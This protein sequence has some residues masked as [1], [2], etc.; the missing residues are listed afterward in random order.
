MPKLLSFSLF[1]HFLMLSLTHAD[2][3]YAVQKVG[4]IPGGSQVG[5]YGYETTGNRLTKIV[6]GES[7]RNQTIEYGLIGKVASI[8]QVGFTSSIN[9]GPG[10]RR[11]LKV[12]SDG[13]KTFHLPGMDYKITAD[14]TVTTSIRINAKGYSPVAQVDIDSSGGTEYSYFVQDHL[15]SPVVSC[16][17]TGT[18]QT[19]IRYDVWG[20][21]TEATGV[22]NIPNTTAEIE[23]AEKNRGYTGHELMAKFNIGQWNGRIFDYEIGAFPQ[24]DKFI[25]GRSIAAL[26]RYALGQNNNPNVTD[27]SGWLR[28]TFAPS[29]AEGDI[30]IMAKTAFGGDLAHQRQKWL[31][32]ASSVGNDDH[33]LELSRESMR[34]GPFQKDYFLF[35]ISGETDYIVRIQASE[36][37]NQTVMQ[38]KISKLRSRLLERFG[39]VPLPE[40]EDEFELLAQHVA[41]FN[42]NL[43]HTN[44]LAA[45]DDNT[46]NAWRHLS[47]F[48]TADGKLDGTRALADLNSKL[49]SGWASAARL[50][51]EQRGIN[52]EHKLLEARE[53]E[54]Q[55]VLAT[56]PPEEIVGGVSW[57]QGGPPPAHGD[58]EDDD[59]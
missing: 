33:Q 18:V 10:G 46:I 27:S 48:R 32:I 6:Q 29:V 1:V 49:G 8:S 50:R 16:N 47:Q 38:N 40:P 12:N 55:R 28:F 58:I 52:E 54:R 56:L 4:T 59:I 9:H 25:Q 35:K 3:P 43:E 2:S 31:E 51:R 53:S 14:D 57:G 44:H 7:D 13:S 20:L 30:R 26:N 23:D 5:L 21:M 22:A 11:Y 39:P 15:G 37:R 36:I 17:N 45:F 24:A 19:R 34:R 42:S 41:S